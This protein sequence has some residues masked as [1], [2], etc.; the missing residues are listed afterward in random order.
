MITAD[1]FEAVRDAATPIFEKSGGGALCVYVDGEPVI[2]IWGGHRDPL[3]RSPWE[4]D[5]MAM[6]WSTSKGV[7]STVLHMLSDRGQLDYDAPI[8]SYWP[9]FGAHGKRQITVRHAMAM[10]AGLYDIRHMIEDPRQMLDH[11]A[12]ATAIAAAAPAHEPGTANAYH[13][14]TYGWIAAELVRRI[15]GVS[16]G[17]FIQTEIAV[18]LGLDGFYIG[19]PRGDVRRVAARPTLPPE[20]TLVRAFAKTVD[21]AIRLFGLSPARIAASFA[22]RRGNEVIPTDE[23]LCAEVPSANGVF[24]A[25]SIARFYAVLGADEGVNGVRLWSAETRRQATEQQ[26]NRRDLVIPLRVGWLL[27]Y[28]RP[29]P[30]KYA[31]QGSFGFYGAFGSG[32]YAEPER[33]LAVGFVVQQGKGLP[34]PKLARM[35][36]EHT[37]RYHR[38]R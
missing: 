30:A 19:L 23:F 36:G 17:S 12:M 2:D 10:E 20:N 14:L 9:E 25:R 5:T 22:P 29:F 16:I 8:A 21:P 1:G 34:L 32:A 28:H 7:T 38:L 24:N 26:N 18:P 31:T 37:D 13:A 15:T 35:I 6:A 33:R 27:G 4:A 11:T 3:S